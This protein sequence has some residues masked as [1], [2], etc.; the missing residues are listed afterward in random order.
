MSRLGSRDTFMSGVVSGRNPSEFELVATQGI[1]PG[2]LRK[3][4]KMPDA[5]GVVRAQHFCG[6]VVMGEHDRRA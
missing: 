3:A 6:T 2:T 5:K 1:S 4:I